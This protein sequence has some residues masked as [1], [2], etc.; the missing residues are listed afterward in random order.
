MYWGYCAGQIL[1]PQI[2]EGVLTND[3]EKH[4]NILP[5]LWPITLSLYKRVN[6]LFYYF[7]MPEILK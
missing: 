7:S 5:N 3:F 4:K 1:F 6:L 2:P